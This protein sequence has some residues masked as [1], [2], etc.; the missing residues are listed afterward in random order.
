MIQITITVDEQVLARARELAQAEGV[1][2][3]EWL[4]VLIRQ[5]VASTPR[6]KPRDPLFGMVAGDPDL[7]DAIDEVVAERFQM[8]L[9][10][11]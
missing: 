5:G 1:S 3:E 6:A 11:P 9:R 7:A 10:S 8:Q 4:R 2:V